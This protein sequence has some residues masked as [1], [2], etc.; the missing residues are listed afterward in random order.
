M[1]VNNYS[2]LTDFISKVKLLILKTPIR[3]LLTHI[4]T[5]IK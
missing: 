5:Q 4:I 3:L 2:L 1:L